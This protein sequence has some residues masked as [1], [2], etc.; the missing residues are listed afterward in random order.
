MNSSTS[1]YSYIKDR[2]KLDKDLK[3][4]LDNGGKIEELPS[5]DSRYKKERLVRRSLFYSV[6]HPFFAKETGLAIERIKAIHRNVKDSTD[7]E[8]ETLWVYFRK[9]E[10][11]L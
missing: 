10:W 7:K 8:L 4:F 5:T 1:T 2:T 11:A 6:H 9:R 3:T